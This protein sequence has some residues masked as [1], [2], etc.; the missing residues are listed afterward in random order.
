M[1]KKSKSTTGPSAFAKPYI[2][3]AAGAL[4]SAYQAAQPGINQLTQQTQGLAGQL[5]D[6]TQQTN[7]LLAQSQG[8]V[9]DVLSGKYM[10]GN[11]YLEQNLAQTRANTIEGVGSMFAGA[12]RYGSGQMDRIASE[13]IANAENTA[14]M[15]NYEQEMGRMGAAA[16]GAPGQI[17]A[18]YIPLEQYRTTA[19]LGAELP[20]AGVNPYVSGIGGLMGGYNT[21]TGK[22]GL[23]SSLIGAL[24]AVGGSWASGGFK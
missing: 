4:Q 20:Y 16:A 11:P 23:G 1:S 14:R 24:G 6:Q 7:P 10:Q 19:A 8:Y 12:G 21:T 5:Y 22:Q 3:G 18:E 17:A 15:A 2:T 13:Q 9:S